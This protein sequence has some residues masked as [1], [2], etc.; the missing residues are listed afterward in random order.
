[1]AETPN[2]PTFN[3]EELNLE[4][5]SVG[6]DK[7]IVAGPSSI[8]KNEAATVAL[9]NDTYKMLRTYC[10]QL[11]KY[12]ELDIGELIIEKGLSL[13]DIMS[14]VVIMNPKMD[15][16][17]ALNTTAIETT[18]TDTSPI[19]DINTPLLSGDLSQLIAVLDH[20]MVLETSWLSGNTLA[21]TLFTSLYVM[22]TNSLKEPFSETNYD[23][24]GAWPS[25]PTS[26]RILHAHQTLITYVMGLIECYRLILREM[27]QG[28]IYEEEDFSC[29]S[30][31][32]S[33]QHDAAPFKGIQLLEKAGH[34]WKLII[35]KYEE[36][37]T[38]S[39]AE[40]D[41]I[42]GVLNRLQFRQHFLASLA[43]LDMI[44]RAGIRYESI[45]RELQL[46]HQ[47][48]ERVQPLSTDEDVSFAFDSHIHRQLNC[49]APPRPITLPSPAE[50]KEFLCKSLLQLDYA[51][52]MASLESASA[53][54][55]TLP[56]FSALTPSPFVRSK[57]LT[58]ITDSF[59]LYNTLPV[60]K[61]FVRDLVS[62]FVSLPKDYVFTF[63]K[64]MAVHT[65]RQTIQ[66]GKFLEQATTIVKETLK[67]RCQNQ[68]RQPRTFSKL[69]IEW[70]MLQTEAEKLDTEWQNSQNAKKQH[71]D[72]GFLT[73]WTY[74]EKLTLMCEMLMAGFKLDVYGQHEYLMINWYIYQLIFKRNRN[75]SAMIDLLE[76][77]NAGSYKLGLLK[78]TCG[79]YDQEH[80]RFAYRFRVFGHVTSP[81]A[82][83]ANEFR[84]NIAEL[85]DISIDGMVNTG[86][87]AL[88]TARNTI[89]EARSWLINRKKVATDT[90]SMPSWWYDSR[91]AELNAYTRVCISDTLAL[92]RLS[93][94]FAT[95]NNT[96]E[97]SNLSSLIV[98][99]FQYHLKSH[100]FTF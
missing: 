35:S 69:I 64:S 73:A 17:M 48:L 3:V 33:F 70:D 66:C 8:S 14:T 95:A 31:G 44:S 54:W 61:P 36:T 37:E 93:Q 67:A 96:N 80:V 45:Q 75:L 25:I 23:V 60:D 91:L 68:S 53:L 98:S 89:A 15:T 27:S 42:N 20:L 51:C 58:L 78:T 22:H 7:E 30:F 55:T 71:Q 99:S 4:Q 83:D 87:S 19:F 63:I 79:S 81:P 28:N 85:L 10:L 92:Q 74:H 5:L 12:I 26:E 84:E 29:S 1:M 56:A 49:Q 88:N 82:V 86:R 57:L 77:S 16:G 59:R 13:W 47:A 43:Q 2:R 39:N 90:T 34:N 38:T 100:R 24:H 65:N 6:T 41:L 11:Q 21:Q 32:V 72:I 97:H 62:A 18:T 94:L 76:R 9:S 52:S 50:A 40:L 46:A